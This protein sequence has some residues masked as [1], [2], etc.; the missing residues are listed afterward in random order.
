MTIGGNIKTKRL[1]HCLTLEELAKRIGT[2][3][4]TIQRYE[5]GVIA[6]I[7]SDK[8]ELLAGALNTTPAYLMG[9]DNDNNER[10]PDFDIFSIPG[11][12]PLPKTYKVPRLGKIAC[13]E[14]LMVEENFEGDDDVA[15][16]I[17]CD[18]SLVC[19]GD[20]MINARIYDGDI[21]YIRQQ[22]IVDNGSIAAVM[23]DGATTLKRVYLFKNKIILQAENPKYEPWVYVNEELENIL[24]L[25][26]AVGFT[27]IIR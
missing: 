16:S 21:V 20:S 27:S 9:W 15:E 19:D 14:P 23:V 2:S 1:Q 11:I 18:F 13:G 3:K 17:K 26:K 24:I 10:S 22:S 6:N 12:M 25:G 5:S 8:I 4:Q 7:P